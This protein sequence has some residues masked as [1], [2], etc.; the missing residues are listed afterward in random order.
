MTAETAVPP[1]SAR[2]HHGVVVPD[3]VEDVVEPGVEL[4]GC[5]AEGHP[6]SRSDDE[7]PPFDLR[8]T[9]RRTQP[10]RSVRTSRTSPHA[11]PPP[12]YIQMPSGP[13][14]RR[15]C[16]DRRSRRRRTRRT[17]WI[18]PGM[19]KT[20]TMKPRNSRANVPESPPLRTVGSTR[21]T[22]IRSGAT[23]G[24][25]RARPPVA[26]RAA[27]RTN[28]GRACLPAAMSGASGPP[29]SG[30]G[31]LGRQ[32]DRANADRALEGRRAPVSRLPPR[33]RGPDACAL[34]E[35][36]PR[37]RRRSARGD[38][39][40]RAVDR[41]HPGSRPLPPRRVPR[42]RR[43]AG[44]LVR[45]R[46]RTRGM[47]KSAPRRARSPQGP[48]ALGPEERRRAGRNWRV[49]SAWPLPAPRCRSNRTSVI[50][51]HPSRPI[52][53]SQSPS[54]P[55]PRRGGHR[56]VSRRRWRRSP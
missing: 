10:A 49:T 28:H 7:S 9:G 21:G 3:Q 37:H 30:E 2:L 33:R 44:P 35:R 26:A 48:A 29:A 5:D 32:A 47:P 17:S 38:R 8:R 23:S 56:H 27:S 13:T 15:A 46:G 6:G 41:S 54:D 45:S 16:S 34:T 51:P 53:G 50:S 39:R 42:R 12:R 36:A 14:R 1:P 43:R 55:P 31:W 4:V 11:T 22:T 19:T 25:I 40:S 20:A 18:D 52:S 24:T